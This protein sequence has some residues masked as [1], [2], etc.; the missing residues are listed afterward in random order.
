[1]IR[2]IGTALAHLAGRAHPGAT[3]MGR[4]SASS[5]V[6][7]AC[8]AFPADA[9]E[10]PA[11]TGAPQAM[12]SGHGVRRSKN[13]GLRFSRR[14]RAPCPPAHGG[15]AGEKGE[16]HDIELRREAASA[17]DRAKDQHGG[18][19]EARSG[20]LILK[21]FHARPRQLV[22]RSFLGWPAGPWT[23]SHVTR[24]RRLRLVEAAPEILVLHGLAGRGLPAVPAP[25]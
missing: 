20:L 23:H 10:E 14:I 9:G 11:S 15:Q 18:I 5:Q 16:A 4:V 22:R 8:S 7:T 1:M 21:G 2:M 17:P 25:A 3:A 12:A 6:M 24:W 13:T 19:I